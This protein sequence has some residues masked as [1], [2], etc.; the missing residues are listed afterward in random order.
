MLPKCLYF[1]IPKVISDKISDFSFVVKKKKKRLIFY[2]RFRI[3]MMMA[4]D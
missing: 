3:V 4:Y 2:Y 1:R